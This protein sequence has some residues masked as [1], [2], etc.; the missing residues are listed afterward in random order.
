MRP[1]ALTQERVARGVHDC[2]AGRGET[3]DGW[4]PARICMAHPASSTQTSAGDGL[5]APGHGRAGSIQTGAV[6]SHVR[7]RARVTCAAWH[8]S[9]YDLVHAQQFEV[10]SLLIEEHL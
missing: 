6:R 10:G 8:N 5:T 9:Q 1:A 3:P 2:H 7:L 4:R